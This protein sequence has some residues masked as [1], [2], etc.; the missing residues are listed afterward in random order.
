M[1]FP[2]EY[3]LPYENADLTKK[4]G[5]L[6]DRRLLLAHGTADTTVNPQHSM[7]FAKEMIHQGILFQQIVRQFMQINQSAPQ[8]ETTIER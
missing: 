4:V 3:N 6:N 8:T 1:G 5:N 7:L 2:N